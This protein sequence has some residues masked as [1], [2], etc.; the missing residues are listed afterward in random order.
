[1]SR[2][3]QLLILGALTVLMAAAR[4]CDIKVEITPGGPPNNPR[5]DH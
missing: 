1:M 2:L 3:T 5:S 4:V